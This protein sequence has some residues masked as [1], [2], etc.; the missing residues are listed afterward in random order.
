MAAPREHLTT[1]CGD[2]EGWEINGGEPGVDMMRRVTELFREAEYRDIADEKTFSVLLKILSRASHEVL[3][4]G[5]EL[6]PSLEHWLDLSAECFRCLRNACVQ[7]ARN[8]N[9]I[10]DVGLIEETLSLIKMFSSSSNCSES[11]LVAFRCG[12]QFLGNVAGGNQGSQNRIWNHAFPQLFLSCLSHEDEK[13]ATY[14][15]MV[16]FT[17]M[18]EDKMA[19][20]MVPANLRVAVSVIT[21]SSKRPYVDWLY[22]IV[23]DRFLRYPELLK[24]IYAS[25]SHSDRVVLLEMIMS[26]VSD[27]SPLSAEELAS[28]QEV[29]EFLSECFQNQCGAVLKLASSRDCDEPEAVVVVRLLDILCEMTS[30]SEHL[31]CLQSC[32]GLLDTVLDTLRLTH[33]AGKQSKNIFTSSHTASLGSDLTH[34]AVGFKAHLIRLIANLC[35][36][37]KENQDK[38]Y[39]LD[40]IPLIL[41]NCS[42]DDNNPFLNQ[43]AVYTIRNLTEHNERN[44][45]VIANLER[46]GLADPSVLERMGLAVEERDNKLFLRSVKKM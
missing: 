42:I 46:Q 22:L 8:Q 40:G 36:R 33:L 12:L 19:D 10:R 18:G 25:V 23:T 30:D 24:Q 7:C 44:Q 45:G 21:A 15:S 38:I 35:Y 16:L 1:V 11:C 2:L 37:N 41:D 20:F 5:A 26:K 39:Q 17:C 32:S 6:D 28:L 9:T 14:G 43:W 31:T 29:A 34:A 13:V 27:K 3:N 4:K